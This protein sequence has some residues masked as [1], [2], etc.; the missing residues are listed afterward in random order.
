M[1]SWRYYALFMLY[2]LMTS[3]SDIVLCWKYVAEDPNTRGVLNKCLYRE[4]PS[5]PL[6][7]LTLLYTIF[8]E[9]GTPFVHLFL[10]N[11]T[12]FTYLV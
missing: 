12:P 9:K 5:N 8:H 2:R 1:L 4:S 10:T 11:G 6:P 3:A 7:Q